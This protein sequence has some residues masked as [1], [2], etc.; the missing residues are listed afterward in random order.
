MR[1]KTTSDAKLRRGSHVQGRGQGERLPVP[2]AMPSGQL[3][4]D[5]VDGSVAHSGGPGHVRQGQ[6]QHK[7]PEPGQSYRLL[8]DHD[9]PGSDSGEGLHHRQIV[10]IAR[11][12]TRN[13]C[14]ILVPI[15][16]RNTGGHSQTVLV[17]LH[18]KEESIQ[19][20]RPYDHSHTRHE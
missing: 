20:G 8:P 14:G 7:L 12:Y 13:V 9:L 5:C 16:V 19:S 2:S 3:R 6:D 15:V 10:F 17:F 1:H 18:Q 4:Q 11:R